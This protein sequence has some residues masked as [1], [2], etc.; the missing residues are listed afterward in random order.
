MERV[1]LLKTIF[2]NSLSKLVMLSLLLFAQSCM[3]T[4]A[5]SRKSLLSSSNTSTPNATTNL[6]TFT[7]GNN[8]PSLNY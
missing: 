2:K 4:P 5:T 7:E 3:P 1:N 6:P 8:F